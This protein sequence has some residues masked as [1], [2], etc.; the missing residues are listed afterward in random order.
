MNTGL[1]VH[2]VIPLLG[3]AE[4]TSPQNINDLSLWL[5]RWQVQQAEHLNNL[6]TTVNHIVV[7]T[8]KVFTVVE[9]LVEL[10]NGTSQQNVLLQ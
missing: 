4:Q 3:F 8:D 9:I 10:T 2:L 1:L 7:D 6:A 5:Q